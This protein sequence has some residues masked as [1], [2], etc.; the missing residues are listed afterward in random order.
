MRGEAA[1]VPDP[2]GG[3]ELGE[4]LGLQH[5]FGAR[6]HDGTL[7]IARRQPEILGP[8]TA[9]ARIEARVR[10]GSLALEETGEALEIA[11]DGKDEAETGDSVAKR[12]DPVLQGWGG[13]G[14]QGHW[15]GSSLGPAERG[16][17]SRPPPVPPGSHAAG[18]A[19]DPVSD[20]NPSLTK[21]LQD[22]GVTRCDG[23]F[24]STSRS[25]SRGPA[26]RSAGR[27]RSRRG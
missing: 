14:S 9:S 1:F 23:S 17:G 7:G 6:G 13:F 18:F 25:L 19:A 5:P 15:R 27:R 3:H 16:G 24:T 11:L 22:G 12:L 26:R 10:E 2:T 20:A 4:I 21:R 8:E